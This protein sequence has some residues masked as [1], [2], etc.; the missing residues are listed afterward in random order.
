MWNRDRGAPVLGVAQGWA[1]DEGLGRLLRITAALEKD[2]LT[3]SESS[4][5]LAE[6]ARDHVASRIVFELWFSI[7]GRALIATP[8]LPRADLRARPPRWAPEPCGTQS[9]RYSSPLRNSCELHNV[10]KF[11]L[12]AGYQPKST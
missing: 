1:E 11:R 4:R 3:L 9:N 12:V 10:S 6:R 7:H 5:P 8:V 2:I